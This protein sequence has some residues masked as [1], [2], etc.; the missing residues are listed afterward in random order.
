M[1]HQMFDD[2]L[3]EEFIAKFFGYGNFDGDYWFVGLE[4][5][6]G[7]SFTE[8]EK[9]LNVWE[10]HGKP[11]LEDAA[12]YHRAIGLGHFF[13]PKK[14]KRQP[15]W[16]GLI[17]MLF[18]FQ[19]KKHTS[20]KASDVNLYQ[21][22]SFLQRNSQSCSIEL[23]PLPSPSM[24]DWLYSNHS[25]LPY[26]RNRALYRQRF[27]KKRAD[28]MREYITAYGPKLV[29]FYGLHPEYVEWWKYI[30]DKDFTTQQVTP[31]FSAEFARNDH[32][33]F[34]ISRHPTAFGTT[35]EYLHELGMAIAKFANT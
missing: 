4:Q 27:A 23:L 18:G 24:N 11:V 12:D 6:G 8:I 28:K 7:N 10:N 22:D 13:D 1:A 29:I 5:G 30:A 32:T 25:D 17:R 31:K 19:G 15:T 20:I 9:R 33:V 14:P 3:L 2:K 34:A 16:S 35:N 26:L 21:R